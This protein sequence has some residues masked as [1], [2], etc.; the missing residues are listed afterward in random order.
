MSEFFTSLSALERRNLKAHAHHLDPVVMIGNEGISKAVLKAIDLQLLAHELIKVRIFSEDR[1]ERALMAQQI[2]E[3]LQAHLVQHIGKLLVLFRPHAQKSKIDPT[4][5]YSTANAAVL[6]P[7]PASVK[8]SGHI[9]KKLLAAGKTLSKRKSP[10]VKDPTDERRNP[11]QI[12]QEYRK[13]AQRA[14]RRG[15]RRAR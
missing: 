6:K 12:A 15:A 7:S 11:G 9:A 13:A 2:C 14:S 5:P 10:P 8:P 1:A 3:E 4:L